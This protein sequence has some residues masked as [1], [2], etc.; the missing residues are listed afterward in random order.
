MLAS[1]SDRARHLGDPRFITA[2]VERLCSA[3]YAAELAAR[4]ASDQAIEVSGLAYHESQ[5]TT[6]VCVLDAEGNAVSLTH[7]LG[8]ASGVVTPGLGFIFNNCMYQYHPFPGHPNSIAPGKSRMT[9]ISGTIF[10][11]NDR[12]WLVTG[13]LGGTRMPGAVLHTILNIIDHGNSPIEAV[14][15]ARF[16]AESLWLEMERRLYFDLR[17]RL[18]SLGWRLR[19]SP[20][21]YDRAFGLAFAALRDGDGKFHG[22]SDPR[23]AGGI[24]IA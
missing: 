1:F 7:T 22:G 8:S 21:G 9:G 16:H 11:K 18:T 13:A 19:V 20:R 4:V 23:G 14:E 3:E 2:P 24:S 12:P 15:K 5:H 10:L 17:E 6:H